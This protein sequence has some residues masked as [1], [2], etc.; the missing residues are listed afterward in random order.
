MD[1]VVAIFNEEVKYESS[2]RAIVDDFSFIDLIS[3][4]EH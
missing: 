3:D 4:I 1:P 2:V